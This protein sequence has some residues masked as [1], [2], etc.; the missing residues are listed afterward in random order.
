[1]FLGTSSQHTKDLQVGA[2]IFLLGD[3]CEIKII[4]NEMADVGHSGVSRPRVYLIITNTTELMMIHEP[5][6]LYMQ[7]SSSIKGLISTSASDYLTASDLEIK[8]AAYEVAQTRKLNFRSNTT[9]LT[10]LLNDRE[11]RVTNNL[12]HEYE[13]RQ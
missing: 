6:D 9:D 4:R 8:M 5:A 2:I 7:V 10:Y 11:R 3:I 1:V 12:D 13:R